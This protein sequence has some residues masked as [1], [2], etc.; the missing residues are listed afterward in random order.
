[1]NMH[2]F[3]ELVFSENDDFLREVEKDRVFTF[4]RV[5]FHVHKFVEM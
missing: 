3:K 4:E 1:M 2:C 5:C